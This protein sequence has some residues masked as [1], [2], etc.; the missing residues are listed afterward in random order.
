MSVVEGNLPLS[1]FN[2]IFNPQKLFK[3]LLKLFQEGELGNKLLFCK[4]LL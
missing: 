1:T 2:H 4:R 3:T